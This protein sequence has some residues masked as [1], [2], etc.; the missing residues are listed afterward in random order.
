MSGARETRAAPG[1]IGVRSISPLEETGFGRALRL[2]GFR[3]LAVRLS[4]CSCWSFILELWPKGGIAVRQPPYTRRSP[5]VLL[6]AASTPRSA[7]PR[8]VLGRDVLRDLAGSHHSGSGDADRL[9]RRDRIV[10]AGDMRRV[11][12]G[13]DHDEIVPGDLP[14]VDAV[15]CDDDIWADFA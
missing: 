13:P 1:S 6:A 15:A 9:Q 3:R 10:G 7:R 8:L 4:L 14:A 12:A 5:P 2:V 11:G